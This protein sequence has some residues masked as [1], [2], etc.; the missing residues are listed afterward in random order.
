M[1]VNRGI[2]ADNQV[3]G[4]QGNGIDA[5]ALTNVTISRNVVS[6]SGAAGICLFD[7]FTY[8]DHKS[9]TDSVIIS[10]NNL[11]DNGQWAGNPHLGAITLGG[12]TTNVTLTDNVITDQQV[13][14]TQKYGVYG[15]PGANLSGLAIDASNR[16]VGS[17]VSAVGGTA[18]ARGES[19]SG[20][21]TR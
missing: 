13:N 1:R 5:L 15:H 9:N 16:I 19:G 11:S 17:R 3:T 10:R 8:G 2:I 4:A 18:S 21:R 6:R 12:T 20:G 14:K 7:S